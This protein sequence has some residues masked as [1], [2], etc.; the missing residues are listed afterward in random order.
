MHDPKGGEGRFAHLAAE[1][2]LTL[3]GD[4]LAIDRFVIDGE[5]MVGDGGA[6]TAGYPI[7][8]SFGVVA[9]T[10]FGVLMAELREAVGAV[11]DTYTGISLLPHDAGLWCRLLARD[12]VTFRRGMQALWRTARRHLTGEEPASRRK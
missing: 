9:N 8:A 12:G 3:D 2:I 11:V 10:D 5:A 1:T 4:V 7:H 6:I